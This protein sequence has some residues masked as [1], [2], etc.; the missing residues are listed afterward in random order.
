MPA[1][2]SLRQRFLTE[3]DED[4]VGLWSVVRDAEL[5]YPDRNARQIRSTVL[6]L[7]QNLLLEG[8][9]RAGFPAEDGAFRGLRNTPERIV[10]RIEHEWPENR[11]PTIGEGLWFT[12]KRRSGRN[13]ASYIRK[14]GAVEGKKMYDRLQREAALASAHAR[15]KKQIATGRT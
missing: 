1:T 11:R 2:A 14:Y 9:I 13:L 8:E 7:L 12:R 3:C 10:A 6:R 4:H 15:H 5:A